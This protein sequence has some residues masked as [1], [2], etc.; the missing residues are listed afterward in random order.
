MARLRRV[1]TGRVVPPTTSVF[2][3]F[4]VVLFNLGAAPAVVEVAGSPRLDNR[5]AWTREDARSF[6]SALGDEGTGLYGVAGARR[7]LRG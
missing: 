2:V 4:S 5:F 7:R 6:L 1:A 3:V